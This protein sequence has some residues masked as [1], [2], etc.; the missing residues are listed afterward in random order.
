MMNLVD[1]RR[2]LARD[3]RTAVPLW[4]QLRDAL[5]EEIERQELRE[6]DRLPTEAE[7]EERFG[8]SR[9]T[10]RQAVGALESEGLLERVQGRG[11]FV[12]TPR[13]RHL[14]VLTSFSEL[15]RSQ[16]HRPSHRPLAQR[17]E[18][19]PV[20]AV[21]ALGLADATPCRFLERLLIA[22]DEPVGIARSWLPLEVLGP[23]DGPVVRAVEAGRSLYALL[24][25]RS[26]ELVPAHGVETIRPT[27]ADASASRLLGC[28]QGTALLHIRRATWTAAVRPLEWTELV[29]VPDRY[30]YRVELRSPPTGTSDD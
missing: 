15:L 5:R 18:E 21:Q 19:A 24:A 23:H 11:T 29:F 3:R 26:P 10:I 30:E 20:Q 14:P 27:L 6:G 25:E 12:A 9:S 22:D 17:V 2:T 8:V 7:L 28:E 1:G 16:G 13:I 4:V